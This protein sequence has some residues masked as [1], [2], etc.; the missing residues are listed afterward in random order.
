MTRIGHYQIFFPTYWQ[1]ILPAR[2]SR[3]A[4]NFPDQT[5]L[6]N[7]SVPTSFGCLI[8]GIPERHLIHKAFFEIA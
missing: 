8:G 4:Q 2:R 1:C 3:L 6:I 7:I 5:A